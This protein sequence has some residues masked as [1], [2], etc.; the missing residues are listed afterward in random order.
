MD[1][2]AARR[3]TRSAGLQTLIKEAMII[4]PGPSRL[5]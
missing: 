2:M 3:L 4:L 1:Y 5:K